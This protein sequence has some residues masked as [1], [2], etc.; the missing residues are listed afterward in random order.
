MPCGVYFIESSGFIKVGYSTDV[1]GRI[2]ELQ[3][4]NPHELLFLGYIELPSAQALRLERILHKH[5]GPYRH[6]FEWFEDNESLRD[7]IEEHAVRP[8][9]VQG[10][11]LS[12]LFPNA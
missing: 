6:R 12:G 1:M 5:F 2:G 8:G 11:P 4:S 9:P 10:D 7:Y 3:R